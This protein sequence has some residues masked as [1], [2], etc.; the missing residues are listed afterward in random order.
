MLW[1]IVE[2]ISGVNRELIK[3]GIKTAAKDYVA[4]NTCKCGC[5][6]WVH[7]LRTDGAGPCKKCN[8][9]KGFDPKDGE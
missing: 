3:E 9:C 2:K 1:E 4:R 7:E 8:A 6:K 5:I